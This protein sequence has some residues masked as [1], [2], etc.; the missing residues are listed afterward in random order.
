MIDDRRLHAVKRKPLGLEPQPMTPDEFRAEAGRQFEALSE[1][2]PDRTNGEIAIAA[3][4]ATVRQAIE[5][6]RWGE[7]RPPME[8]FSIRDA[9]DRAHDKLEALLDH[10]EGI[11]TR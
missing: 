1:A 3:T 11:L 8:S 5:R 7:L 10:Y 9:W 2:N 4:L 6:Q